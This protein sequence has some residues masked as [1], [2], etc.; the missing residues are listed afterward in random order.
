MAYSPIEQGRLPGHPEIRGVAARHG[1]MPAQVALAWLLQQD[2]PVIIPRAGTPAH[3]REN[4][5]ALDVHLTEQDLAQL[6]RAFPAP[7]GPRPQSPDERGNKVTADLFQKYRSVEDYARGS[8]EELERDIQ[9][10]GF[11]HTKAEHIRAAAQRILTVYGGEVPH[12]MEDLL[13][14]PGVARKTANVVLSNVKG[15]RLFPR[16]NV[17]HPSKAHALRCSSR[18]RH[19]KRRFWRFR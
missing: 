8:Q 16:D 10:L 7:T 1:T 19:K 6:A 4:R 3:V 18:G 14:L 13:T 11:Y 9:S 17:F 15:D 2:G 12:S 5:A